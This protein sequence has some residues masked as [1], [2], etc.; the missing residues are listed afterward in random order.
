MGYTRVAAAGEVSLPYPFLLCENLPASHLL[1]PGCRL[2]IFTATGDP[3]VHA[4]Q[5]SSE[6]W[7]GLSEGKAQVGPWVDRQP[8]EQRPHPH[9]G[10][11]TQPATQRGPSGSLWPG[12][13]CGGRG[14]HKHRRKNTGVAHRPPSP[15]YVLRAEQGLGGT[16][17][18]GPSQT[19]T[20]VPPCSYH[21]AL[22]RSS[23]PRG[24]PGKAHGS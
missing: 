2:S 24:S 13:H 21:S 22:L 7:Q 11:S 10:H 17:T 1:I 8:S 16:G 19:T 18:C 14:S 23:A 6:S 4:D 12:L 9:G 3:T 20:W 5:V 15:G